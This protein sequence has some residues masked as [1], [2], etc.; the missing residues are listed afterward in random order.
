MEAFRWNKEHSYWHL[1]DKN[2]NKHCYLLQIKAPQIEQHEIKDAIVY[3]E[4]TSHVYI[5][6]E[7]DLEDEKTWAPKTKPF[8]SV[9]DVLEY[10][11]ET[12]GY[13]PKFRQPEEG[14]I[15]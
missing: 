8:S 11:D 2:C 1:L 5:L 7:V 9:W 14:D 10:L 3:R 13:L 15:C 6:V 4:T 12:L